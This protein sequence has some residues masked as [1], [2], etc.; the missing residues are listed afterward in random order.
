MLR[1]LCYV[2][3]GQGLDAR[4]HCQLRNLLP[5]MTPVLLPDARLKYVPCRVPKTIRLQWH[6]LQHD[7]YDTAMPG[8]A[9]A[10]WSN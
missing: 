4:L 7:F 9:G 10:R 6:Q 1:C 5:S 8:G 2:N 3:Y